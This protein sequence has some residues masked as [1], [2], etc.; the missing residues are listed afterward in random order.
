MYGE[1]FF[2][3]NV[4]VAIL[5]VKRNNEIYGEATS[6]STGP[7]MNARIKGFGQNT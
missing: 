2:K 5:A 4:N 1:H 6:W 3:L 7:K